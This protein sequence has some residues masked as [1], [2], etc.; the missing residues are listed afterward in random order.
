[1]GETAVFGIIRPC[2][3]RLTEGLRAEWMAHLCG[4]CLALRTDHGQ[5]SRVVTN[6][7]GLVVSVL[8]EAQVPRRPDSRRTAGPCPLRGMRTAPVARGEG[9]RLAAAVS[10]VL[11]SAKIRDHADDGD[12]A[13]GHRPMAAPAPWRPDRSSVPHAGDE[14]RSGHLPSRA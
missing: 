7:D 3:H 6:Y 1:M 8:T 10:L 11:A 9:T 14:E 5:L 4:L 13:L 2:T 12:G